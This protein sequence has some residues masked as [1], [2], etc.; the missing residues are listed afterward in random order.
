MERM[1][2]Q[3]AATGK[4]S[5]TP[6]YERLPHGPHRLGA[7]EV[8]RNQRSRMHGAM[9][10]AVAE[11]GY[12]GTSV[13][14]V[15]GLAGVS[16]RSFYEQFANKQECFLAT[17]DLIATRGAWRVSAAYRAADGDV[18]E[19]LQAA[20]DELGQAIS[21]NWKSASLVMLEA[22]KVGTPA[23][24]RLRRAS[25]TFEQMLGACFEQTTEAGPLPGPVIRG[26]AGGLHAAMSR[27]LR[28]E[29]AQTAPQLADE[30]FRWTL[31]FQTPAA[32]QLAERLSE[33]ARRALAQGRK[34]PSNERLQ[35]PLGKR[36]DE[37]ERLLEH[38]LHLS[39]I[40][41]YRELSAPQ[42]A[43]AANVSI[44]AFFELFD[45]KE[46]CFLAALDMLGEQLLELAADPD[47]RSTEWPY[48]VRRTIR[49]LMHFLAEHP[50]YAQTI[51][52]GAYAAGPEAIERN[53]TLAHGIAARLTEGA[54]EQARSALAVQGVAGA[55]SHTV[56]CHVASGQIQLL[57][58]LSDYLTYIVLTPFIGAEQ[59][60]ALVIEDA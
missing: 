49:E 9:I 3:H 44:D 45:G 36:D 57:S 28:E 2:M 48:A 59:A 56:R 12:D 40:E 13:K 11:R 30:M 33:R 24:L 23:L 41:G 22:P 10:E 8:V 47:L 5:L 14:Q 35:E 21:T 26:I 46:E 29:S 43:D 34:A 32:K 38:A 54:P 25:A 51:A 4:A 6:I 37:R 55:L 15:V 50:I 53:L 19:R 42:I 16:R 39:V 27:C 1:Q 31:L 18:H 17:Y 20:F 7:D 60:A 58:V 52:E